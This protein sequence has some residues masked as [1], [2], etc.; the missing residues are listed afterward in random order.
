MNEGISK[1]IQCVWASKELSPIFMVLIQ[2]NKHNLEE[3]R[4]G[5]GERGESGKK[6]RRKA[7]KMLRGETKLVLN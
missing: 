7:E 6:R 2:S 1:Q 4:K 5:E 3:G